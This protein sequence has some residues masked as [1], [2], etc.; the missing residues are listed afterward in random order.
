MMTKQPSEQVRE[1]HHPPGGNA[2]AVAT[3]QR[4]AVGTGG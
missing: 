1:A 3:L 4:R 2:Q